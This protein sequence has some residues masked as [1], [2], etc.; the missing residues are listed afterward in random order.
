MCLWLIDS[1]SKLVYTCYLATQVVPFLIQNMIKFT[2]LEFQLD[3]RF[4]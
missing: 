3:T 1:I 4:N 2:S